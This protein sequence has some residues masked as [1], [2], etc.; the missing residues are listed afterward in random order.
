[1]LV[2]LLFGFVKRRQEWMLLEEG[3][4][5]HR[6]ILEEY[7]PQF[8]DQAISVLT[9]GALVAYA[10]Y[11][12]SPEVAQKLGTPYLNLTIP[13]VVGPYTSVN[14]TLTLLSN[15]IRTDPIAS[16]EYSEK[17]DEPDNRFLYNFA[18]IQSIATSHGQNDAGMFELNFRDERYLPF[19]GAGAESRWRIEMPKDC[20]AFDFDTISDVVLHLNY[21][22]RD[23]GELLKKAAREAVIAPAQEGLVR[24]FS[25]RHEFPNQWHKFIHP[26]DD[27]QTHHLELDFDI[28]RFPF[29][30]RGKEMTIDAI[31]ILINL[32]EQVEFNDG[33]LA[34]PSVSHGQPAVDG[35]FKK[36]VGPGGTLTN[37]PQIRVVSIGQTVPLKW[38]LQMQP[39][40]S[41]SIEDIDDVWIVAQYSVT[42]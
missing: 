28:E 7:S 31:D 40:S 42:N 13:C 5:K 10:L 30:F 11:T 3:A 26:T 24:M 41:V 34:L 33:D 1:M 17:T 14:C 21:T 39:S 15:K 4:P 25:G 2:A 38:W 6:R 27:P 20:N 18:S 36:W 9:S 32:K 23:G 19:E 35:D 37:V 16:G 29:V 22:A 12:M 8:L